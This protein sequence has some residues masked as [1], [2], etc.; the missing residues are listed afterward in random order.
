L[1][2]FFPIAIGKDHP[3]ELDIEEEIVIDFAGSLAQKHFC[4]FFFAKKEG[5]KSRR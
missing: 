2:S 5:A 1:E 3:A 4:F